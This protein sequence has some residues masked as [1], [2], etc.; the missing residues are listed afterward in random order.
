M[1]KTTL[2][3]SRNSNNLNISKKEILEDYKLASISRQVSLIG[4]REVLTGKAKF[5]I[6]GAG[7]EVPQLAM[8]KAFKFGFKTKKSAINAGLELLVQ[9]KAQLNLKKFKGKLHW[10]GEL[11]KMRS[12]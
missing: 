10:E 1:A 9:S 5:G 7:K 11:D 6:F 12:D 8:A 4:R 2:T 3:M